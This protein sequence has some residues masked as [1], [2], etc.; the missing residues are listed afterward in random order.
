MEFCSVLAAVPTGRE[1]WVVDADDL[2]IDA[3]G[4]GHINHVA[5]DVAETMRYGRFSITRW[6]VKQHG[7]AGIQPARIARRCCRQSEAGEGARM[8]SKE[9]ISLVSFCRLTC[10]VNCSNV[11]R[12][13]DIALRSKASMDQCL[14]ASV[15]T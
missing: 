13:P 7:A 14:P 3:D 2:S 15:S 10:S 9:M 6:A 8:R 1:R 11:T 12:R 5:E 4:V